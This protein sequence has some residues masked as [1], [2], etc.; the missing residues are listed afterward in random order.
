MGQ[1]EG[2]EKANSIEIIGVQAGLEV[3]EKWPPSKC[4]CE[5]ITADCV[6]SKR[7]SHRLIAES[8]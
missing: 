2:W 7:F 5:K 6:L 4:V 1:G 8:S 3:R